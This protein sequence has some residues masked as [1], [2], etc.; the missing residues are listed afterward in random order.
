MSVWE[1]VGGGGGGDTVNSVTS[2]G[3]PNGYTE[4]WLGNPL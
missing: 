1:R 2:I 3:C 4:R